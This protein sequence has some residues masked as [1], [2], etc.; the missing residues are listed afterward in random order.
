MNT[1]GGEMKF[2]IRKIDSDLFYEK[3]ESNEW[4]KNECGK[5]TITVKSINSVLKKR[6]TCHPFIRW[7]VSVRRV[8]WKFHVTDF[9][10]KSRF[11]VKFSLYAS[12]KAENIETIAIANFDSEYLFV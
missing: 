5:N 6:A 2:R 9:W 7:T 4:E 3:W 12:K 11:H 8:R 10:M 1:E